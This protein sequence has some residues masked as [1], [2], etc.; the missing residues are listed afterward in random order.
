MKHFNRLFTQQRLFVLFLGIMLVPNIFLCFTE[1]LPLLFKGSYLLIPGALYLLLLNL[2]RKPGITFWALLPL[3]FVGAFQLVLLYLFGNSVIAS[4]MFLNMFTTNSG[5][6]FELLGK[7]APAVIGVFL[8]YIPALALAVYSIRRPDTLRPLFRKRVFMLALIMLCCGVFT[9]TPAH[10]KAP[11]IARLDNLYPIN[12]FNNA[13]FAL[14]SWRAAQEY[15]HT[16]KNFDY[17][18]VST[19]ESNL[20]EIYIFVIG[21]TSRAENW[22]LYGYERNTT[23]LL[24]A[25]HDIIRFDDVLTQI[26]ATHKSVPLMLCPASALDYDQI[27][28]QKSLITAFKQAGFHTAFISNQLRNGSFTDFFADEADC[29]LYLTAPKDTPH[30]NDNALLPVV[31]SLLHSQAP[32]QLIILHTYGSHFNYCERYTPDCRRFT[33]DHIEKID[34]KNRQAMI[35]AYDNSIAATDQFLD[36]VIDRLDRT[37]KTAAMLYL[38]D[39]G[40]DLLDDSRERFLHASPR[41][42][43]Y[44]LHVP[45]ILWFSPRY[46]SQFPHDIEQAQAHRITPFDSRVAFHTLLDIGGIATD[47][48]NDKLSLVSASFHPGKRY[49]MGERN[50]PIPVQHIPF[51]K[52]DRHAFE[53]HN[54][55]A[56]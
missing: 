5:E 17:Q 45:C 4:D 50:T 53:L 32:K 34:R 39:H 20:P 1:P 26:N 10:R 22:G 2:S 40:E 54:I 3:H 49:Y 18:A 55:S 11:H 7:L 36:Q 41:P 33:P 38:S 13:R 6:A 14:L 35:N 24:C 37:G 44:Q 48:R 43:Y 56:Q 47:Y 23:P 27:Y 51:G 21:E 42:T 29:T 28:R 19:R 25:R 16:S 30:L 12:A 52:E 46:T 31:D 15:R 9:Y 8:L